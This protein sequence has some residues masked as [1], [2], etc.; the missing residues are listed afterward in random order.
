MK[1]LF[2]LICLTLKQYAIGQIINWSTPVDV[3]AAQFGN[4]HPRIVLDAASN[5][6]ILWGNSMTNE[7]Y[8]SRWNGS[9][10]TTPV[11]LN[12]STIPVFAASWAGPDIASFGDTVYV[13]Y[14]HTPEDTNHIYITKSFDGGNTFS[15]PV[16]VDNIG[17]DISRF[18]VVTA[19]STGNP[20]VAFMHFEPMWMNP[21]YVVATSSDFGNTFNTELLASGFSGGQVCDCCPATLVSA[22]NYTTMLYRDNLSNVRNM[23]AGISTDGGATFGNGIAIDQTNWP[24]NSCPSSGPDGVIIGDTL[25]SVFMSGATGNFLVYHSAASLTNLTSGN[26]TAFTGFTA[27]LNSQNFPRI[28]SSG[29]STAI[30]WL[31]TTNNVDQIMFQFTDNIQ[32]G[33]PIL[34]DT[35]TSGNQLEN[36]DIAVSPGAVHLIWENSTTGT[37]RYQKGT[38]ITTNAPEPLNDFAI[39]LYPNPATDYVKVKMENVKR[40]LINIAIF[41]LYGQPVYDQ[42]NL[43]D[44]ELLDIRGLATGMYSVKI[45][46]DGISQFQKLLVEGN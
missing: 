43:K 30:T 19:D 15:L 10:F 20:L 32:N 24:Y 8:F 37:I 41:N 31:Q 6:L 9:A 39:Q 25:Y 23:W 38:Y 5:P 7:A 36:T 22:Q 26:S 4:D 2:L 1:Y 17:A 29:N 11:A 12:P 35:I 27:G 16:Q 3:S 46:I 42:R 44:L 14:K 28:A 33:F 21:Q 18:P 40:S 45:S 34:I 13:T